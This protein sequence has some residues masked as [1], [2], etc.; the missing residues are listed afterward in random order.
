[1]K[2]KALFLAF[3][4]VFSPAVMAMQMPPKSAQEASKVKPLLKLMINALFARSQ[5]KIHLKMNS[6]SLIAA[7]ILFA[8]RV[9]MASSKMRAILL[10]KIKLPNNAISLLHNMDMFRAIN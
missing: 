8:P 3:F 4:T 9:K 7:R 10:H 5:L 2:F 1:M 6:K